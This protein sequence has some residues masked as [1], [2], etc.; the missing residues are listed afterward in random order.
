MPEGIT[1]FDVAAELNK[2]SLEVKSRLGHLL[3]TIRGPVPQNI[4]QTKSGGDGVIPQFTHVASNLQSTLEH[5]TEIERWLG[6]NKAAQGIAA[7]R[8][9]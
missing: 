6:S 8:S 1:L 5:I 7:A 4:N 9:Y 2:M 3:D